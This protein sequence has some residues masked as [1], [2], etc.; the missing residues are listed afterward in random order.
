M[1]AQSLRIEAAISMMR[2]MQPQTSDAEKFRADVLVALNGLSV[3]GDEGGGASKHS[4]RSNQQN[5]KE[6]KW[7]QDPVTWETMVDPVKATDGHTYDRWTVICN[8]MLMSPLTPHDSR[9][10]SIAVE[11]LDVRS[12]LFQKFP[13]QEARFKAKRAEYRDGALLEAML[14]HYGDAATMLKHVLDWD[15]QDIECFNQLK[16]IQESFN[17][18]TDL[19]EQDV[20]VIEDVS[21]SSAENDVDMPH[22]LINQGLWQSGMD[23]IKNTSSTVLGNDTELLARQESSESWHDALESIT[24]S[25]IV[26]PQLLHPSRLDSARSNSRLLALSSD[27]LCCKF[28]S[29]HATV[30]DAGICVGAAIADIAVPAPAEMERPT[31]V[32]Y[33]EISILEGD[34]VVGVGFTGLDSFCDDHMPGSYDNSCGYNG[35]SGS[36][37]SKGK[38]CHLSKHVAK[39]IVAVGDT[40]GA[41]VHHGLNELFFIHNGSPVYS[42]LNRI[43]GPLMP[44]V[45][46]GSVRAHVKVAFGNASFPFYPK[47]MRPSRLL[48]PRMDMAHNVS[49]SA[50]GLTARY[51][52]ASTSQNKVAT[53]RADCGVW[54]QDVARERFYFEMTITDVNK[55]DKNHTSLTIGFTYSSCY[56]KDWR[57]GLYRGSCGYCG[58][59]GNLF[60]GCWSMAQELF[61]PTFSFGDII[62]AGIYFATDTTFFCKNGREVGHTKW[63]RSSAYEVVDDLFM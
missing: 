23:S 18:D 41:G 34:N 1:D 22:A 40:I 2:S 5:A 25:A 11:D 28:H 37:F 51:G 21:I 6:L 27:G 15:P 12:R 59:D 3:E 26:Q 57:P 61:G 46:L 24:S 20:F 47:K 4:F 33:F 9:P 56:R 19:Q 42:I 58:A 29:T 13:H 50:D 55:D 36:F 44:V 49:L 17:D 38:K 45:A 32:S 10:F 54:P 52:Y 60:I 35:D 16:Y 62:G 63:L 48:A 7:Y 14:E 31:A 8:N 43:S 30:T 53:L 39:P